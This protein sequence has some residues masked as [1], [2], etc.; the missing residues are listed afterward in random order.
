MSSLRGRSLLIPGR[1][2]WTQGWRSTEKFY[3]SGHR[4]VCCNGAQIEVWSAPLQ[5]WLV[6]APPSGVRNIILGFSG[7]GPCDIILQKVYFPTACVFLFGKK[8]AEC[9]MLQ[10]A[11]RHQSPLKSRPEKGGG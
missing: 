9:M 5:E 7:L 3:I 1:H 8:L 10:L 2:L 11:F 6:S 4:D